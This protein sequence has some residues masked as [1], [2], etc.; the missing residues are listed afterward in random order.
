MVY[1]VSGFS[2]VGRKNID[3]TGDSVQFSNFCDNNAHSSISISFEDSREGEE[4]SE[5]SES[6]SNRSRERLEISYSEST[7]GI[8]FQDSQ[9]QVCGLLY[10]IPVFRI[11]CFFDPKDPGFGIIFSG[12]RILL[13]EIKIS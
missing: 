5:D 1:Y 9:A 12:S 4:E 6:F 11:R 3:A 13:H 7:G 8:T 10:N 2:S